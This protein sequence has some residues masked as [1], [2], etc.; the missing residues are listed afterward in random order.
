MRRTVLAV[1]AL[2]CGI[3]GPAL[4]MAETRM[5]SGS[6]TYRERIALPDD[7]E[8]QVE[9]AAPDGQ[10]VTRSEPARGRQV[11][12]DFNLEL[13]EGPLVLRATILVQDRLAWRSGSVPI[14]A[15]ASD[16]DLGPLSLHGHITQRPRGWLLCG[17]RIFGLGFAGEDA[18]LSLGQDSRRLPALLAPANSGARFADD[19]PHAVWIKEDGAIIR[20]QGDEMPACNSLALPPETALT[21]RGNEPGW[22]LTL[23]ADG[24]AL[25]TEGGLTAALSPLPEPDA[26]P[27]HLRWSFPGLEFTVTA[28]PCADSMSGM[29]YPFAAG[30][31][32][33]GLDLTGCAGDPLLL[34]QGDWRVMQIEGHDLA[35]GSEAPDF[36]V[37]GDAVSGFS[38]C[39]RFNAR[40]VLDGESLRIGPAAVTRM[41]CP[42]DQMA[43][44]AAFLAALTATDRFDIGPDGGLILIAADRD[45]LRA[46]R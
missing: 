31:Q 38:G 40:A 18:V 44:E 19:G 11:P 21:A 30:V 42:P 36:T 35:E 12:F 26:G 32:G 37:T 10:V 14:P 3:L 7:A 4:S 34:L 24:A 46:E 16:A 39:N 13:P 17:E 8:W 41:A 29:P 33:E 6:L 15:G 45:L 2:L 23:N 43:L 28:G 25:S 9:I 27:D 22:V 20:W 5:I 1:P